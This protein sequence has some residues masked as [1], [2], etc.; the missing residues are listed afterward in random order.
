VNRSLVR[1]AVTLIALNAALAVIIL[2]I[3]RMGHTEGRILGTSMLATVS[4]LLAMVQIPALR[5]DRLGWLP[6]LGIAASIIGFV[7]ATVGIWFEF[8]SEVGLKTLGTAYTLATAGAI[9]AILS[10]W[11]IRGSASW[12]SRSMPGVVGA[13]AAVLIVGIWAEVD[14]EAYWRSFGAMSVLVAAIG[15]LIPVL[16]RSSGEPHSLRIN[17]C[18]FCGGG[19][20]ANTSEVISCGQCAQQFRVQVSD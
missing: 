9:M 12:I 1:I 19:M 2:L 5:D 3:G 14:S 18:P 11:P 16:H 7:L 15:L 6:K 8:E 17:H 20:A 13:T 4:A 10:S